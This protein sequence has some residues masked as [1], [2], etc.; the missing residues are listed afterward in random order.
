MDTDVQ[1]IK[2]FDGLLNNPMFLGYEMNDYIGTGIIGAEKMNPF[3]GGLLDFYTDKI[4][5]V[6]F[7]QNPMIF[8]T[9]LE[10]KPEYNNNCVILDRNKLSPF[11]EDDGRRTDQIHPGGGAG[12]H[13]TQEPAVYCRCH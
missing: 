11:A 5:K 10:E 12:L 3:V 7:Y 2:S 6:D 4:W 1:V 9:L 8:S 13:Q